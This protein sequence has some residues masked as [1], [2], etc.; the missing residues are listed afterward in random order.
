MCTGVVASISSTGAV[1]IVQLVL[2][3][4]DP[5]WRGDCYTCAYVCDVSV[6][7]YIW[8]L[9]C[10]RARYLTKKGKKTGPLAL[11]FHH[12]VLSVY[13][14][15]LHGQ[16]TS[17]WK[18]N[19]KILRRLQTL[20]DPVRGL[21]LWQECRTVAFIKYIL[22]VWQSETQEALLWT[23]NDLLIFILWLLFCF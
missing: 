10:L 21:M 20:N 11:S 2:I 17:I 1:T 23:V 8:R 4:S 19:W 7:F 18:N 14:R 15:R 9:E 13:R 3:M 16:I 5:D 22:L 6:M 12:L